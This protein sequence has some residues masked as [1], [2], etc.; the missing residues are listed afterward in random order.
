[1][2]ATLSMAMPVGGQTAIT[3]FLLLY[4][5]LC[6]LIDGLGSLRARFFTSRPPPL[7]MARKQS[8]CARKP[9]SPHHFPGR[10]SS[11]FLLLQRRKKQQPNS[12]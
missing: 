9:N 6:A 10:L 8:A 7:V 5:E 2:V 12:L 4:Y 11:F 1:M 3:I